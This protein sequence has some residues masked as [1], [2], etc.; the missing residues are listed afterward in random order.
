MAKVRNVSGEQLYAV[1]LNRLVQPDEVVEVPD[2]RLDG[3]TCQPMT[4]A[5]ET[6]APTKSKGA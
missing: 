2:D 4:W 6:P 5:D 1:E 3:Y